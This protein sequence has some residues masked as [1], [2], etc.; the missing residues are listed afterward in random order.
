MTTLRQIITNK[1]HAFYQRY[2]PSILSNTEVIN[3][4]VDFALTQGVSA[5]NSALLNRYGDYLDSDQSNLATVVETESIRKKVEIFYLKFEPSKL[6]M[7]ED[8]EAIVQWTILYGLGKLNEKLRQKYGADLTSVT[9]EDVKIILRKYYAGLNLENEKTEEDYQVLIDWAQFHSFS[10][11]NQKLVEKYGKGFSEVSRVQKENELREKLKKFYEVHDKRQLEDSANLEFT[12]NWAK[13]NGETKLNEKLQQKYGHNL[14]TITKTAAVAVAKSKKEKR[15]SKR[16]SKSLMEVE[17]SPQVEQQVQLDEQKVWRYKMLIRFFLARHDKE[18]LYD[19]GINEALEILLESGEAYLNEQ[20][21]EEYG[22]D[23][24]V[25]EEQ[26]EEFETKFVNFYKIYDPEKLEK[27]EEDENKKVNAFIESVAGWT[28]VH[29]ENKINNKLM[30]KYDDDLNATG[31]KKKLALFY[32][33]VGEVRTEVEV[34]NIAEWA[35]RK[36]LKKLN[37]LLKQK[38]GKN[39]EDHFLLEEESE[40]EPEDEHEEEHVNEYFRKTT[41]EDYQEVHQ[42]NQTGKRVDVPEIDS[43]HDHG[44]EEEENKPAVQ[45]PL[46]DQLKTFYKFHDPEKQNDGALIRSNVLFIL[47]NGIDKFNKA[48]MEHYGESLNGAVGRKK[49]RSPYKSNFSF[50]SLDNTVQGDDIYAPY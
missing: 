9:I 13:R 18:K 4:Q 12:L 31:L 22:E 32:S 11:L 48:L 26:Y 8:V 47:Q 2:N 37:K 44:E 50:E 6:T 15:R 1:L 20:L 42:P 30:D 40:S 7:G 14:N 16:R 25:I 38:Y 10:A 49:S 5:L 35:F 29:G 45:K 41:H 23:L 46:V 34:S 27:K 28:L 19:N 36:G 24:N 3:A 17:P 39:L 33:A 21:R 43:F